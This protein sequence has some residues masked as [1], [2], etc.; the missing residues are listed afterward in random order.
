V[1]TDS[2]KPRDGAFLEKVGY[3]DPLPAREVIHLEQ[4]RIAAWMSK[5]AQPTEAVRGLMKRAS[6]RP[7]P[8]APP[9]GVETAP[10][11][12]PAAQAAGS[13]SAETSGGEEAPPEA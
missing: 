1:V 4:E 10:P 13:E 8:E 5:G 12:E 6:R 3:Y 2:R 9:S 7:A 11:P